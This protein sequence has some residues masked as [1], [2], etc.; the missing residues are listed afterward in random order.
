MRRMFF[1]ATSANP[2]T[3][4]WDMS[5]VK[6]TSLM[7]YRATLSQSNYEALLINWNAQAL[8][9]GLSFDGGN[10]TYCSGAAANA[11]ANMIN[12]DGWAIHDGGHSCAE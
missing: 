12:S 2:D 3:S 8:Q 11:R 4:G 5:A 6:N 10:S 9:P 1:Q 7:F